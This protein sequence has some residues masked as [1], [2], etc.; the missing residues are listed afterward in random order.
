MQA[1]VLTMLLS[2]AALGTQAQTVEFYGSPTSAISAGAVVPAGKKLLWTSGVVAD[3]AD[4]TAAPTSR[5]RYGDTKTQALS[6]LKKFESA[7]KTRGLSFRDVLMLRVYVT[8]DPEKG[9]KHDYPGWFEAYGQYFGTKQNPT[10]PAR[11]TLG[12]AALVNPLMLIEIEMVA[13]FP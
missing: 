1:I 8:P 3:Q 13:V 6:I 4:S 9:G 12:L 7:L 5:A 11:S 2:A 10:K